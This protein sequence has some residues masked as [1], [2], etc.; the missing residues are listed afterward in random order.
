MIKKTNTKHETQRPLDKQVKAKTAKR[1]SGSSVKAVKLPPLTATSE[2]QVT[3]AVYEPKAEQVLVSG[4][5]N[6]WQGTPLTRHAN[7]DWKTTVALAPGRH[8]YKFIVDGKWKID[9]RA[10]HSTPN[11]F[12]TL[13]SVIEVKA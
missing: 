6:D 1:D 3:F 8:E 11:A 7:R 9:P 5:F 13:N 12:G 4:A 10:S 2:R